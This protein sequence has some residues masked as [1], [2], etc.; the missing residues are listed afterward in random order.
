MLKR[1]AKTVLNVLLFLCIIIVAYLSFLRGLFLE[2]VSAKNLNDFNL[3]EIKKLTKYSSG[4]IHDWLDEYLKEYD[5]PIEILNEVEI[6]QKELVNEYINSFIETAKNGEDV[7][8][9]PED[10]IKE[11]MIKGVNAYNKK[12]NKNLSM[13]KITIFLNDITGKLKTALKIIHQNISFFGWFRFLLNDTVYYSFIV[14]MISLIVIMAITYQ[15]EFFFSIGGI[16]IFSGLTLLLTYQIFR[17]SSLQNIFEFL[18]FDLISLKNKFL[19]SGIVFIIIGFL[20]LITY[21]IIDT[22]KAKRTKSKCA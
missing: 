20:F 8:E 18:P 15:K 4:D 5:I 10:K 17:L 2:N 3:E 16:I 19:S 11:I 21:K 12:Y 7:P 1:I 22:Y 13:D 6:E 9:I 14:I